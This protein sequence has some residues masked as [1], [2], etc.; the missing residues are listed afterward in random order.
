ML[1]ELV[2]A[3]MSPINAGIPLRGMALIL[4][5][6]VGAVGKV[7]GDVTGFMKLSE[8]TSETSDREGT[9]R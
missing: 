5:P 9:S 7:T 2:Y 8:D 6:R 4:Y 3:E 1:F